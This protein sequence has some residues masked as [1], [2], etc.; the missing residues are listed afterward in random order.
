LTNFNALGNFKYLNS[1]SPNSRQSIA[2]T[3]KK[4]KVYIIKELFTNIERY[5]TELTHGLGSYVDLQ[6]HFLANAAESM[7]QELSNFLRR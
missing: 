6:L 4:N 5:D 2:S 7:K 3:F 1:E